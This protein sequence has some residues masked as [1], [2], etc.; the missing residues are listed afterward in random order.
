MRDVER[1]SQDDIDG[2]R[3]V[4]A[5]IRAAAKDKGVSQNAL[6]QRCGLTSGR[7]SKIMSPAGPVIKVGTMLQLLRGL[8]ITATRLLEENP[9]AEFFEGDPIPPPLRKGR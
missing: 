1:I 3:R 4:R 6:A 8:G 2:M 9:G 5:H 7:M